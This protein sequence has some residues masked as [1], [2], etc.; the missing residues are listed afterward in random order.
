MRMNE[1]VEGLGVAGLQSVEVQCR[2]RTR[3]AGACLKM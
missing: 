3:R 2:K 1:A